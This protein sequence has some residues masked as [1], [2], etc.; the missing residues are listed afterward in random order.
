[1]QYVDRGQGLSTRL[2][3]RRIARDTA[4][5]AASY[6]RGR[7]A[8]GGGLALRDSLHAHAAG[9]GAGAQGRLLLL[10]EL[11]V[12]AHIVQAGEGD[13]ALHAAGL[14]GQRFVAANR[15]ARHGA[16]LK[17]ELHFDAASGV[18]GCSEG[19]E[20]V[21]GKI[22]DCDAARMLQMRDHSG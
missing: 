16:T 22:G 4:C 13:G 9:A 5:I 1:M 17:R 7:A 21:V 8:G 11:A 20:R 15:G 2:I 12:R 3:D 19:R 10:G 6:L 14:G 18:P